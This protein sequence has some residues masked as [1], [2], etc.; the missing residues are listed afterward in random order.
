MAIFLDTGFYL[1]LVHSKDAH[2]EQSKS[3]LNKVK[4][5]IFGRL[6][7][8]NYVMVETATLAGSRSGNDERVINN[9]Q[10]YFIGDLIL[11][12]SIRPTGNDDEKTWDLFRKVNSGNKE[13]I[14][15]FV[16]CSNLILCKR[17]QIDQIVSYDGHFEG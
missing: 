8:F 5:G 2:H 7:T 13:K 10:R 9:T 4:A 17:Y 12:V 1:G 11:A 16:V 15:S 14:I 3:I 6:Y